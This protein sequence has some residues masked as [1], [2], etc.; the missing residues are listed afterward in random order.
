MLQTMTA[1][2]GVNTHSTDNDSTLTGN[3]G[4]LINNEKKVSVDLRKVRKY[5]KDDLFYRVVD[6]FEDDQ[7]KV[8]SFLYK[9]FMTR[10]KRAV[11]GRGPDDD[12]DS[13]TKAYMKYL[14]TRVTSKKSYNKWLALKRSNAYQSV[15]DRFFRKFVFCCLNLINHQKRHLIFTT[16]MRPRFV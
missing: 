5:V 4:D 15:Q 6:V 2:D 8:D 3:I 11:T 12:T 14:W 16:S 10:A 9:D 13:D 7:L 1:S